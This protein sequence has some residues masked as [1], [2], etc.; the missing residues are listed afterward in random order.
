MDETTFRLNIRQTFLFTG[1]LL[2]IKVKQ[3]FLELGGSVFLET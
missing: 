3:M 2:I 1:L